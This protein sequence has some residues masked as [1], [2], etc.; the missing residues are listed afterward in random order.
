MLRLGVGAARRLAV[1]LDQPGPE[2]VAF[3]LAHA[4]Q[5]RLDIRISLERDL[6]LEVFVARDLV[7]PVGAAELGGGSGL[8][9]AKKLLNLDALESPLVLGQ[10]IPLRNA[11][12]GRS[13]KGGSGDACCGNGLQC[14]HLVGGSAL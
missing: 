2:H 8:D 3:A 13:P 7:E 4:L 10:K 5:E 6:A 12:L 1:V 9:V 11:H 14:A